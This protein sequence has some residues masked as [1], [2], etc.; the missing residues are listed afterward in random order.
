MDFDPDP[1]LVNRLLSPKNGVVHEIMQSNQDI[2]S[3][4]TVWRQRSL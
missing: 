1:I 2:A 3:Q 4:H